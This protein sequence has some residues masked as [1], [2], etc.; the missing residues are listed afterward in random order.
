MYTIPFMTWTWTKLSELREKVDTDT[1]TTTTPILFMGWAR[2]TYAQFRIK[3]TELPNGNKFDKILVTHEGD[4]TT[5]EGM[6]CHPEYKR[7]E[8][9]Q[10]DL[11]KGLRFLK[12]GFS[13]L[14]R[15]SLFLFDFAPINDN[16]EYILAIPTTGEEIC[17]EIY[18][19]DQ[20]GG[21]VLLVKREL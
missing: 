5:A 10:E 20:Y 17:F 11:G 18:G 7:Y 1:T 16:E 3:K 2:R 19:V 6:Y 21:L 13:K 4:W 12:K 14:N 15:R 8:D 9:V